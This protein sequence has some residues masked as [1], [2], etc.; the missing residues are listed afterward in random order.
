MMRMFGTSA[1]TGRRS[2]PRSSA[3]LTAVVSTA[4]DQH[5][6]ELIDLS[7]TGARVRTAWLAADGDEVEFLAEKVRATGQVVWCDGNH[8]AIDFDTPIAAAEVTRIRTLAAS[9]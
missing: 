3:P 8:V 1:A 7:R 4:D 5:W 2:V 6:T 9:R